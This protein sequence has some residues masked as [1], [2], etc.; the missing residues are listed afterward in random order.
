M[1]FIKKMLSFNDNPSSKRVVGVLASIAIIAYAFI[2]P[3]VNSNNSVLILA[4][5]GLGFTTLEKIF[6]RK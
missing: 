5:S 3:S 6:P 4:M 1:E 2:W